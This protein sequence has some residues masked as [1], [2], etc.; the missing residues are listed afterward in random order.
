MKV[1][2]VYSGNLFGGIES[3]L[4]ACARV[5]VDASRI[6]HEFALCFDERL[7]SELRAA[8]RPVHL[9]GPVRMSRPVSAHAARQALVAVLREGRHDRVICHAPWSQAIFGG[10]V[11]RTGTPLVF[12]AHDRMTGRHWTERIARHVRPQLVVC[13]SRFTDATKASLYPGIR[14]V[15]V[16]PPVP[17]VRPARERRYVRMSLDTPEPAVVIVQASRCEAWKGHRVLLEA[18]ASVK[19]V[20]GWIWWLAGGAQ[21]PDEAVFLASLRRQAEEAGID[22][23]IRWLGQRADVP[24]LLGAADIY[25]QAN[26]DPEPFGIAFVEALSAGLPAVAA[27][28]GGVTEILDPSCGL[29]VPPRDPSALAVALRSLIVDESRRR[30]LAGA[31]PERAAAL[32]DPLT[33]VRCLAAA[34]ESTSPLEMAG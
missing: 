22:D 21:R 28:H 1:L 15:V 33:Q 4:L 25:C 18:L 2:H 11:T 10:V 14:S 16:Y 20:P 6:E 31:A 13:N 9:L 12:W 34:L 27:G 32:C 29:L 5:P 3:M 24:T 19:D 26:V 7:A 8:G 30:A 23:R 17:A